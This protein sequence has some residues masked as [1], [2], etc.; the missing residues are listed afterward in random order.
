MFLTLECDFESD[1]S[2][3]P[4]T[5]SF[6]DNPK[7]TGSQNFLQVI[8]LAKFDCLGVI[9]LELRLFVLEDNLV[10]IFDLEVGD[11]SVLKFL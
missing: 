10:E 11:Q 7:S 2:F 4:F 9:F 1:G 5:K 6:A 3:G 8:K